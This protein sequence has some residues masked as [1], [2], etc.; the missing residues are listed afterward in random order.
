MATWGRDRLASVD[1]RALAGRISALLWLAGA[2]TLLLTLA[3]PGTEVQPIT[4]VVLVAGFA[5]VWGAGMLLAV[6]WDRAPVPLF[7]VSSLLGLAI[8]AGL[9]AATGTTDSP[10]R[11]YTW[12]VVAYAAFFFTPR[13]ALAY[14]LACAAVYGAPLVYDANAVNDNLLRQLV[15]V[16]PIYCLVGGIV[17]AGRELLAGLSRQTSELESEQ[18]RLAAEQSSLRRVATAV[19][20]GSPPAGIFALASSEAGRL[21]GAESAAIVRYRDA[22]RGIVLGR[23][24]AG[25][26][27]RN[28]LS[29]VSELTPGSLLDRLRAG[30]PIARDQTG[31]DP[32][33]V[34]MAAPVHT[35]AAPWGALVV[36]GRPPHE[37]GHGSEERLQEYADL[38][39]IALA[40][41]EDR[42]R[43]DSHAATDHLTGLPNHRAFRQ[44]LADE[45][46]RAR[47]HDRPLTVALVDI[48]GFRELN[49]RA[50][51]EIA[52][53]VLAEVGRRLGRAVREE[54]V[55]ARM[56]GDE[57][58]VIFVESDR[59]DALLIADRARRA[60]AEAPLRHRLRTTISIGLCDLEAATSEDE[61]LRRADAA[62]YWAKEHGRDL[63]WLYDPGVVRELDERQ[64]TREL[65][66]SH[67]LIGLRALAR[68]IDAKDPDTQEHSERVAVL[69]V[70]LAAARG[71]PPERVALLRDA[72][73]LHDVGKIGIP[74]AIL[75]KAERLDQ[76]ELAIV[77]EHPVLGARIV[78]DV[79]DEEQ[80]AWIARHH[81]RPDGRGYPE[82]LDG[83]AVPE[84]ASLLALAD[85]WDVMVSD[86][87]YSPPLEM[88]EAL[89]EAQ[90]GAG[91]QF[92][93]S[94]VQALQALA[95]RG[96]LL[97]AA[98]RMHQPTA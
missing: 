28:A 2:A 12:F 89:A 33:L 62:L 76:A 67:A 4:L 26:Q 95:D 16:V 21:L 78:G 88:S 65:D 30:E 27:N 58:G 96:E 63:C 7:H 75:L 6:Q 17:V 70:R 47:R 42:A 14:W 8:V 35:G 69:A 80:V 18:R 31:D 3:L 74:D 82:A 45:V 77:R 40:N 68:A 64:R 29:S 83:E 49:D 22:D 52:D 46:A 85:A 54:D 59:H 90:A 10:A 66:R 19:A 24:T 79:L 94:S 5:V 36:A 73:L 87:S 71:W 91:T 50:G 92:H 11:D 56:G 34:R 48:D 61:L 86:R 20:A 57:F 44:R 23:W 72:A 38:I 15:V 97:P 98:A 43:L 37:L 32:P 60:V 39:A 51:L 53:D 1:E 9:A 55:L 84:G 41:A 93:E 13:Q 81:E 25:E